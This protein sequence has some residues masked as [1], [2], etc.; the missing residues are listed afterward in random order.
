MKGRLKTLFERK[1]ALV[2]EGDALLDAA[3]AENRDFTE[4]EQSRYDAIGEDMKTIER[5]VAREQEQLERQAALSFDVESAISTD[6]PNP[7]AGQ[8]VVGHN[9][10]ADRPFSTFGEQLMAIVQ[11]GVNRGMAPDPRLKFEMAASGANEG[12]ASEGGFLVQKD[13]SSALLDRMNDMGDVYSRCRE[14]PL[15]ENSN[16]TK[17]PCVDETSR[18]NGSRFGGVQAYWKNEA[19]TATAT[20]PRFGLVELDLKKLIAL[21]YATD[22]VLVDAVQLEA[23]ATTAFAEELVFRFED[24]VINGTGAG[25]PLGILNSGCLVTVAKETSQTA[26]T[27]VTANVQKMVKRLPIRS[28]R[29]AVWFVNQDVMDQLWSLTLGSGTAVVLLF[30]PATG[31]PGELSP[32]GT[33]GGRPVFPIEYCATLGDAGDIILADMSQYL[34]IEKAK[35]EME[36]SMHVRFIYDENTFRCIWRVDGQPAWRV[37]VTPK[38]G[39]STQS[40]FVALAA[41]A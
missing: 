31:A 16:G 15:G 6:E 13:F 21:M 40:P 38:N 2:S 39:S 19:D 11:A 18:V 12:T 41:R 10:E 5:A 29:N 23:V 37:P 25:Q 27:I 26:D 9:N 7:Y 1:A 17:L 8:V 24:A 30:R 14:I 20:K 33:L 34:R 32:Y 4:E 28:I 22:E 35:R 36:S 3:T